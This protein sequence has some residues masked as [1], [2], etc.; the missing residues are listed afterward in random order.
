MTDGNEGA[1]RDRKQQRERERERKEGRKRK[2]MI[3]D[4][5]AAADKLRQRE[6]TSLRYIPAK[7]ERRSGQEQL[8]DV[9]QFGS[10]QFDDGSTRI[11]TVVARAKCDVLATN[12]VVKKT[13][14]VNSFEE[15]II[16]DA[17]DCCYSFTLLNSAVESHQKEQTNKRVE[18]VSP[19]RGRRSHR[20][21]NEVRIAPP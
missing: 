5:T 4:K 12:Q 1:R 7:A 10:E 18:N 13:E 6:T 16:V 2:N 14:R 19:N 9:P 8:T 15:C 3:Q 11:S 21:I 20:Q 17:L